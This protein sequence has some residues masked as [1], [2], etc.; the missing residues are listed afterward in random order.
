MDLS[1]S[2][3]IMDEYWFVT[4]SRASVGPITRE[5]MRVKF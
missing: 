4:G 3:D 2:E 5:R 1:F